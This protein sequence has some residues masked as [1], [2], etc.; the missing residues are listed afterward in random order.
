MGEALQKGARALWSKIR[1]GGTSPASQAPALPP[2]AGATPP[3]RTRSL[4]NNS[5]PS[6]TGSGQSFASGSAKLSSPFQ[7]SGQLHVLHEEEHDHLHEHDVQPSAALPHDQAVGSGDGDEQDVPGE[8][9]SDHRRAST[10][11]LEGHGHMTPRGGSPPLAA[12]PV[13]QEVLGFVEP[14]PDARPRR[15]PMSLALAA[16]QDRYKQQNGA[17]ADG[18]GNGNK[19]GEGSRTP[20]RGSP[21][22]SAT[23]SMEEV[24]EVR[25]E[26][27][28]SA[29][30][31]DERRQSAYS[32]RSNNGTSTPPRT[33]TRRLTGESINSV[34]SGRHRSG[35]YGS[36][37][38]GGGAAAAGR[39]R[40][41]SKTGHEVADGLRYYLDRSM[42]T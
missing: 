42:G 13:R 3:R 37:E 5:A 29:S 10:G 17:D 21:P 25:G 30:A 15:A 38:P 4:S 40:S 32:A 35:S 24:A 33:P 9:A 11:D 28:L 8:G 2:K 19:N 39:S 36:I 6:P 16:R 23:G 12:R 20:R 34:G 7:N 41:G 14:R 1:P 27:M 26:G 18:N 22:P 31:L